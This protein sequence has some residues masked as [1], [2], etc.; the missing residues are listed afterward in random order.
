[1]ENKIDFIVIGAP[2][3]GTTSLHNYLLKHPSIHLPKNKELHFFAYKDKLPKYNGTGDMESAHIKY[4]ITNNLEYFE[5]FSKEKNIMNGEIA[6]H[7]L[8][9]ENSAKNIFEHNPKMKIIAILRDPVERAFSNYRHN[10]KMNRETETFAKALQLEDKRIENGWG[11]A[12][13]Y[14]TVGLYHKHLSKYFTYFDKNSILI[15]DYKDFSKKPNIILNKIFHFLQV[16]KISIDTS[17]KYNVT[18]KKY[19]WL[20]KFLKGNNSLKRIARSTFPKRN[21]KWIK[22]KLNQLNQKSTS[23]N[24]PLNEQ[25]KLRLEFQEDILAL[26]HLLDKDF[27]YWRKE[28]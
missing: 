21:R 18:E 6:P 4:A 20:E 7:Y 10:V 25:K 8:H 22:R 3:C 14:K 24:I 26:E 17:T 12:W 27:S 15:I 5:Q 23:D 19:N 13:R 11:P 1:M 28:H 16:E 2:K 9:L